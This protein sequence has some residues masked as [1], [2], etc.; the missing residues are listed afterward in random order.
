MGLGEMPTLS[1]S[2][3]AGET[4]LQIY[5][6]FTSL[7]TALLPLS[8]STNRHYTKQTAPCRLIKQYEVILQCL[9]TFCSSTRRGDGISKKVINHCHL[10]LS[11]ERPSQKSNRMEWNFHFG[12]FTLEAM[13]CFLIIAIRGME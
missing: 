3:N 5:I 6:T 10:G 7:I 12:H 8:K 1:P 9:G 11:S 13:L 2:K 4:P